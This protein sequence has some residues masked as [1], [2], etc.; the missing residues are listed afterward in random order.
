MNT[1]PLLAL[2]TVALLQTP[3]ARAQSVSVAGTTQTAAAAGLSAAASEVVKLAKA[4]VGEPV[5]LSYI[6]QSPSLFSLSAT[7]I[8]GLKD[9][10]ISAPEV[11]AM[12][13]HDGAIR[14]QAA[15]PAATAPLTLP[16]AAA[17]VAPTTSAAPPAPTAS[18]QPSTVDPAAVP[19]TAPAPA[20]QLEVVPVAPG[21]DYAWT[22]GWWSWNG[23]T[24]IWFGGY[25][26]Y[27]TRPGHVFINGNFYHGRGREEIRGFR[28]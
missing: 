23:N 17:Q 21:P 27:P 9:A 20:P 1:K 26:A 3:T 5:V 8:V 2:M 25:W 11:T 6:G 13:N 15:V 12:L 4:G 14:G 19:P 16:P 24:W 7:D 22:P 10:G 28:R 18:A